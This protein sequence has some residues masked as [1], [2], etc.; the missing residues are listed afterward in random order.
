MF[1]KEL[2]NAGWQL[3]NNALGFVGS[4]I[5]A[6]A[7]G[8]IRKVVLKTNPLSEE[9][10]GNRF[11]LSQVPWEAFNS[12]YQLIECVLGFVGIPQVYGA[13]PHLKEII[14]SLRRADS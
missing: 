1:P 4:E 13:F 11:E 5:I 3:W 12:G 2:G 8:Q 7:K 9:N 6:V 14:V 10:S